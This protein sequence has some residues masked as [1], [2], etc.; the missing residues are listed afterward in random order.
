MRE[1]ADREARATAVVAVRPFGY[2]DKSLIERGQ[3]YRTEKTYQI[4]VRL[5]VEH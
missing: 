5:K 3:K 1:D 4:S 2:A